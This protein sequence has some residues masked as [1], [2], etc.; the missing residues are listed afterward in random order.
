MLIWHT[1]KVVQLCIC[2]RRDADLTCDVVY[3]YMSR[4]PDSGFCGI[5]RVLDK[6]M[7]LHVTMIWTNSSFHLDSFLKEE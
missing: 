1:V 3:F 2:E 4:F 7:A 5:C 6:F